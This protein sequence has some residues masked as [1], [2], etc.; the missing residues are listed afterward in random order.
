MQADICGLVDGRR[1]AGGAALHQVA[2]DLGLAVDDDAPADQGME[3][4]AEAFAG[5]SPLDAVMGEALGMHAGA[6][7]ALAEQVSSALLDHA[8]ADGADDIVAASDP[9]VDAGRAVPGPRLAQ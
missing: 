8:G 6:D 2:G 7:A 3:V 5:E 9:T 1:A 4:A